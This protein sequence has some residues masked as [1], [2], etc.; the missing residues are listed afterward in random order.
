MGRVIL[1]GHKHGRYIRTEL[2]FAKCGT[3]SNYKAHLRRGQKPCRSC[4]QAENRRNQDRRPPRVQAAWSPSCQ[5]QF[6]EMVRRINDDLR[7]RQWRQGA[8]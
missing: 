8:A 2:D 3:A 1:Y 6:G 4:R 5:R 7:R